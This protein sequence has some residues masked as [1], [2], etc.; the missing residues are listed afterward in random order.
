MC[1]TSSR[2]P[3]MSNANSSISV[4]WKYVDWDT[5]SVVVCGISRSGERK[6][7]YRFR[8]A[9]Q[10]VSADCRTASVIR[11]RCAN[12]VVAVRLCRLLGEDSGHGVD[13]HPAPLT[14]PSR[15]RTQRMPA[16][17]TASVS[18][19]VGSLLR[20]G[21]W[22]CGMGCTVP[23]APPLGKRRR[24]ALGRSNASAIVL[25]PAKRRW[26]FARKCIAAEQIEPRH[27]AVGDP[28]SMR[29]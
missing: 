24:R 6:L 17:V 9:D 28:I 13:L 2:R 3:L 21:L 12:V 26:G 15:R 19:A 4:N 8:A 5:F 18:H 11:S 29:R 20:L 1:G 7:L 22:M 27:V 25:Q 10:L 23:M 14:G 16:P